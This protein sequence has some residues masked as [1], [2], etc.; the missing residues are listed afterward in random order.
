[1]PRGRKK[2]DL[3]PT[4]KLPKVVN[5][6][7]VKELVNSPHILNLQEKMQPAQPEDLWQPTPLQALLSEPLKELKPAK[8]DSQIE[9]PK[10]ILP[11]F[12]LNSSF[13][14]R[15]STI[16][17]PKKNKK[18]KH[19]VWPKFS[20]P[21]FSFPEW[22]LKL[23][24]I[25]LPSLKLPEFSQFTKLE[26]VSYS[27]LIPAWH[28]A[29][30][31]F[32]ALAI[33]FI[34]PFKAYSA[35]YNLKNTQND[36][37][38][39][40]TEAFSHLT[41]GKDA[42][43]NG[44]LTAATNELQQSL[45]IFTKA[46]NELNSI[47]PVWRSL[48]SVMPVVGEK[49]KN[50]ER[51]MLAGSNL[52]LAGL[53][54]VYL[55][56]N[57]DAEISLEKIKTTLNEIIPRIEQTN[58]YLMAIDPNF[59][60]EDKRDNF[61]KV[62]QTIFLLSA[63][64][65]KM[66]SLI[67]NL[68]G[69][70]GANETKTYLI[71]FQNNN[72]LRPTGGFMG[73]FAELKIKDGK[74]VKLDIPGEGSYKLAG[75]LKV[76]VLP[77]APIQFL[78][79]KWEFQ[80]SN[81]FADFPTSAKK[82]S[83]FYEKSGGP[84]VDGVIALDTQVLTDLLTLGGSFELPQYQASLTAENAISKI[85][86][87]VEIDYDKVKN[88]PKQIISDLAPLLLNKFLTDKTLLLPLL[89]SLNKNLTQRHIQFYL[90]DK[91]LEQNIIAQGWGGEVKNNQEGD[92]LMVVNSNVGADKTDGV[93]TQT[94]DQKTRILEDGSIINTVTVNRTHKGATLDS[95]TDLQNKDY[96]RFFVPL[97]SELL[98]AQGFEW[99]NESLFKVPEKWYKIDEDLEKISKTQIIDSAS[100]TVITKESS[101]T[102]FG[103]WILT[104]P[105]E[106]SS[107]TITYRLPFQL[108][109]PQK[110]EWQDWLQ[111]IFKEKQDLLSYSLLIQKQAGTIANSFTQQTI[112]PESW[113]LLW[114]NPD[115]VSWENNIS[116]YKT[117]LQED[118]FLG[119]IFEN[120]N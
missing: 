61:Q 27:H 79:R 13:Q 55:F 97:G 82:I 109:P 65:K 19:F 98:S 64:L 37:I 63:D 60:P 29:L 105:G 41:L 42:L 100:G 102:V 57:Q 23:P 52:T 58:Q 74:I 70:L 119:L 69:I 120:H 86:Q 114:T 35:Y 39:T 75:N 11:S 91:T 84:T 28:K 108:T 2:I 85:Q 8:K 89:T 10:V 118:R 107:V 22:R 44:D 16:N 66:D 77:P 30:A 78:K 1:M 106:T 111:K 32:A 72:E 93:I 83:W 5:I 7:F 104:K 68:D 53:P 56:N 96:I 99:P 12:S 115:N 47:N 88:Q 46:Q 21:K 92:F 48:L 73:S 80:D 43:Q 62:R 4:Q 20:L 14:H 94:V 54:L 49:V 45:S 31:G 40:G 26:P 113:Q 81:W 110:A 38:F 51:L 103:N 3:Q 76:A 59:I 17:I 15:V 112:W 6:S 33:I 18:T 34:L 9:L 24:K 71:I 36:L 25:N 95:Y 87:E 50:G 67:K 101:K 90:T 116:T 117:D